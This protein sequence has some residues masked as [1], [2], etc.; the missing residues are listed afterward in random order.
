MISCSALAAREQKMQ[1]T[2]YPA[3]LFAL[4]LFATESLAQTVAPQTGQ[5][6]VS[7]CLLQKK[8]AEGKHETVRVSGLYG[9][10]LDHTVLE[11]AECPSESTWIELALHSPE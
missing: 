11:D 10:G 5:N 7:L 3:F 8:V 2:F 6:T 4:G 9:P 1:K